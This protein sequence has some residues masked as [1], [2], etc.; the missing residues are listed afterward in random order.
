[1]DF[2]PGYE[3]THQRVETALRKQ[4]D[5]LS[6]PDDLLVAMRYSVLSGGKRFR[7][8]LLLKTCDLFPNMRRDPMPCACALEFVHTYSLIHDD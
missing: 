8:V 2:P 3:S 4:L 5:Q 7:P 1:M 6:G